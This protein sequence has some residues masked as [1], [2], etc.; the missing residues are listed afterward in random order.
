MFVPEVPMGTNAPKRL[1]FAFT[2]CLSLVA[3]YQGSAQGAG[4]G[5]AAPYETGLRLR[6]SPAPSAKVL[7]F[8]GLYEKLSVLERKEGLETVGDAEGQWVRVRRAS[9]QSGWCFDAY[10]TAID[11]NAF[12]PV[13]AWNYQTGE[14][15]TSLNGGERKESLSLSYGGKTIDRFP[16]IALSGDHRRMAFTYF[17]KQSSIS[18][19]PTIS[20]QRSLLLYDFDTNALSCVATKQVR[21]SDQ[22]SQ[23]WSEKMDEMGPDPGY[24]EGFIV[25]R[26]LRESA[27]NHAGSRIVYNSSEDAPGS[28]CDIA[29]KDLR[30]GTVVE[31]SIPTCFY[32][33]RYLN[34]CVYY[35]A[36]GYSSRFLYPG[37][38]F[39][40][41]LKPFYE[42]GGE[43]DGTCHSLRAVSG[44]GECYV[45]DTR[46]EKSELS[47][48]IECYSSLESSCDESKRLPNGAGA[49]LIQAKD[50][51]YSILWTHVGGENA[52][53]AS[54]SRLGPGLRVRWT[55]DFSLPSEYSGRSFKA[56]AGGV[57]VVS[58]EFA[59]A[60]RSSPRVVAYYVLDSGKV[61]SYVIDREERR[62]F[63]S[64]FPLK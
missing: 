54:L 64:Y 48:S 29:E 47:A 24:P 56:F 31:K 30:D 16:D 40:T 21:F 7:G 11:P 10:L 23:Y 44:N 55:R 19:P 45:L 27:L 14:V 28:Y 9:G 57:M 3:A 36:N 58:Q 13:I 2:L 43:G 59:A 46:W 50:W 32:S 61:D 49:D 51:A 33:P 1:F 35:S 25:D 37:L 20:G 52:D 5:F 18:K 22:Q 34:D 8:L 38:G 39:V 17:V 63:W 42:G 15:E 12:Y 6:A 41:P 26:S 4:L 60:D 53:R 62:D